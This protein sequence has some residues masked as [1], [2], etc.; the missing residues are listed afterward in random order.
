MKVSLSAKLIL[1]LLTFA[2]CALAQAEAGDSN[3]GRGTVR[4]PASARQATPS[5][6]ITTDPTAATRGINQNTISNANT[7][8]TS[9][10]N[11][12]QDG[13]RK[14]KNGSAKA[15]LASAAAYVTSGVFM[16]K[17]IAS[18][19]VGGC[20]AGFAATAAVFAGIGMMTGRAKDAYDGKDVEFDRAAD[21]A[22][23]SGRES[24]D[25]GVGDYD[26][27][28]DIDD[29]DERARQRTQQSI[30]NSL[31]RL[32]QQGLTV[33]PREGVI[34]KPD[35]KRINVSRDMSSPSAMRAAGFSPAQIAEFQAGMDNAAAQMA[36]DATS[37]TA[38]L[39]DES[40][41]GSGSN[42]AG[43]GGPASDE[44]FSIPG[45]G[46]NAG[47]DRAPANVQGLSRDYNGEPIGVAADSLFLMMRR[48]YDFLETQGTFVEI[49]P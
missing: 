43:L 4:T 7:A 25:T 35:G 18:C 6:S 12:A 30:T 16:Q 26:G 27:D 36:T 41:G 47:Q 28:G 46:I 17:F 49:T 33:L 37:A 15:S 5:G 3:G 11:L 40:L 31:R 23:V 34:I 19:G 24:G 32:R 10:R 39:F 13:S 44:T 45:S 9:I 20:N 2:F 48:R 22:T 14:M 42:S 21:Q 8:G 1:S 29:Q 38:D